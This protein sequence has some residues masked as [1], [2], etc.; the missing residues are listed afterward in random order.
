[1]ASWIGYYIAGEAPKFPVKRVLLTPNAIRQGNNHIIDSKIIL[2][3]G[4]SYDVRW[5]LVRQGNSFKVVE[6]QVDLGL[7]LIDITP[8]LRDV[9]VRHIEDN[10]KSVASLVATL[11]KFTR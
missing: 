1:M 7:G 9:F 8:H 2:V 5:I 11:S 6:V 10:G 4:S 3:E